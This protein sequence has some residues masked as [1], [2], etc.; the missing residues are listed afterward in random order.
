MHP[1]IQDKVIDEIRSIFKDQDSEITAE[2]CKNLVYLEMV[3]KEGMRLLPIVPLF[4][5]ETTGD[6][7]LRE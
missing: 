2:D 1:D 5:R 3:I 4:V 6:V 7:T